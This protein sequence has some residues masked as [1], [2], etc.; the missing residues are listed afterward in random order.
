MRGIDRG[1]Y[2]GP[3]P[4]AN[5]RPDGI[6]NVQRGRV[7]KYPSRLPRDEASQRHPRV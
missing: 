5:M 4:P 3:S 6:I 7:A 2:F 1:S